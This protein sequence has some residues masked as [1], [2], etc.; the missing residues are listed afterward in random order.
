MST[1]EKGPIQLA[2]ETKVTEALNPAKLELV[3]ESHL[4]AHHEAMKGV[5]NK[6]THF[7][8]FV[9]SDEFQGKSLMQR[10][11][12]IYNLLNDELQNQGLHALTIKAKTKAEFDKL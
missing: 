9:V 10:H 4:H 3:N 2:I 1:S 6:E 7:K 11:R 8:I 12:L 5:A